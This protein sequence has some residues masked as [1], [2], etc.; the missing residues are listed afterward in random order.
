MQFDFTRNHFEL[1]GLTPG[2]AL[3]S[4]ALE[5]AY[6]ALQSQVHPDK[7]THLSQAEQRAS[8]QWSTRVNEAY[9]VLKAPL[10]RAQYLLQLQGIDALAEHDTAMPGDFL[11]QQMEWRE[12]IQTAR[13]AADV[14]A[15]QTL[16]AELASTARQL[17]GGLAQQLDE[18]HDYAAAAQSVR[19]LK[20]MDKLVAEIHDTYEALET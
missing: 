18:Q 11:M 6:R 20:F 9:Q 17:R 14:T 16:E 4:A 13:A 10:T 1:F 8:M 19:K 15:L 2:F 7:F 12:G 3:D 5:Q